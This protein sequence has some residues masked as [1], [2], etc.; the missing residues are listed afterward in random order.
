M[1][2][3][4]INGPASANYDVDLGPVLVTDN[5]HHTAFSLFNYAETQGPPLSENGLIN[6]M[7]VY[8]CSGST[9]SNCKG[10]GTRWNTTVTKGQKYRLRF[11]NTA[12]D[13]MFKIQIDN[14]NMTVIQNDFVPIK[15]YTTNSLF[16]AIGQRYD[17]II[18]VSNSD[19][20]RTRKI[21]RIEANT[22]S[23][24]GRPTNLKL[25]DPSHR[26]KFL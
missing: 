21:T 1:G 19:L 7:N 18:T 23:R 2:A 13:T 8:N 22:D 4:K 9:D 12:V 10:T 6:G 20:K 26:T 14:H 24:I 5:Y 15:P 16:I 25:L 3:I 17:V 11:V